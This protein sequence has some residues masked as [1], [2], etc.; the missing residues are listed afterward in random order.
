MIQLSDNTQPTWYTRHMFT[1]A[2]ALFFAMVGLDKLTGGY[3]VH[4]FAVI[5]LG[6]WFRY[7]TAAVQIFGAALMVVR[8]TSLIGVGVLG[9]TMVGAIIAQVRFLEGWSAAVV[10]AALLVMILVAGAVEFIDG[11]ER[12]AVL[13]AAG[14]SARGVDI[15]RG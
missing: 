6:Q 1:A 4:V 12:R 10:P 7:F 13:E 11:R 3:W 15:R 2:V 8:R 5:G 9:C 14:S